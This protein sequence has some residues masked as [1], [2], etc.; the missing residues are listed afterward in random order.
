MWKIFSQICLGLH[1][2]QK[3]KIVHRDLK[4]ENILLDFNG[5]V[6]I[7]DFGLATTTALILQQQPGAYWAHSSAEI[8]SSQTGS[9][10]T[11]VYGA[12]ELL[13]GASKSVYGVKV[14]IYSFGIIFFEMCHPPFT[15]E[16]E[17]Y[18]VLKNMRESSIKF[19][20]DFKDKKQTNVNFLTCFFI[21]KIV[22]HF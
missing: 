12:P 8:R 20:D 1:H 17:R 14:D 6:K 3:N 19:P 11:S 21:V 7:T 18:E 2:L 22:T 13:K 5:Q 4:P 15:T 10:G 9:V 16:Y